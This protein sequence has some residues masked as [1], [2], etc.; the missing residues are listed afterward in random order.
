MRKILLASFV[1]T[2]LCPV[3]KAQVNGEYR[4]ATSGPW[5]DA[6]TWEFYQNGWGAAPQF[7]TY[8]DGHVTIR[9]PHTVTIS[10]DLRI[11]ET[12]VDA[13]GTLSVTGGTLRINNNVPA[14]TDLAINGSIN[15]Y[16]AAL[17]TVD[18]GA[19]I[20]GSASFFYNGSTATNDGSIN[21]SS[22]IMGG[23]S[24]QTINGTGSIATFIPFNNA[25]INIGGDQTITSQLAFNYGILHTVGNNRIIIGDGAYVI[26]GSST[27]YIDGNEEFYF[28]GPLGITYTIGDPN[29]YLPIQL[30]PLIATSGGIAARTDAGE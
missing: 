21:T 18:A 11:D 12:T 17:L 19:V 27:T 20:D 7:P 4:S 29:F 26:N 2:I 14:G 9:N 8:A 3:L 28:A 24:P 15:W 25:G 5:N 10:S 6:S 30:T 13:G 1:L 22:F 16:S 23:S